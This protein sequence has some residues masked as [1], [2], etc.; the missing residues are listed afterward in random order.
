[1]AKENKKSE[2]AGNIYNSLFAE[3]RTKN[4]DYKPIYTDGSKVDEAVAAAAVRVDKELTETY[5]K[6]ISIFTAEV[7]AIEIAL[8]EINTCQESKHI[9]FTDSKSALQALQD[10][11]T[12]NPIVRRVLELH[13]QIRKTKDIIFCWVP[14]HVGIRGNEATNRAAK[15]ALESPVSNPMVPVSHWFPKSAQYMK[16]VR[17]DQWEDIENNKLKE[18]VPDLAEHCQLG[19]MNRR[20]EVVLIR[21]RIGHSRLTHSHLLEDEPVNIC[22][23]C[24][25]PFTVKHI[26]L[27]CVDFADTRRLQ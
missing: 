11:W 8:R 12:P 3:I 9:I 2:T 23:G 19:C 25:A 6:N 24:D 18:V 10:I 21:L 20:D 4:P 26:L 5:N 15:A 7:R 14:S 22:I 27:D 13:N 1:M 17:K 16:E